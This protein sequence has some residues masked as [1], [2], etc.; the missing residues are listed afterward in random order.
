MV[1][2]YQ[3]ILGLCLAFWC[4]DAA[5]FYV[6]GVAPQDF[7]K[8]DSIEVRAI[9]MTSS[10]TQL[11]F[12]YYNLPFCKPQSGV[13]EYKSQNLG[14]ILRG[15]RISNTAYDLRMDTPVQCQAL[16]YDGKPT[17]WNVEDSTNLHYRISQEYFVHFIVDNLPSATQFLIPDTNEV[18]YEPGFR[19][20][21][22]RD[23]KMYL[24]N[25]LKFIMSY[26]VD[27]EAEESYRVV[28]FRVETAS[29]DASEYTFN[30]D[31]TCLIKDNPKLQEVK[32]KQGNR[33]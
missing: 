7:K 31:G 23:D 20:G 15:D 19:L 25:H 24:N 10:H 21:V 16:C 11:P 2:T 26:H 9:K 1:K 8:G 22:N 14:E 33:Y 28:G 13:V 30:S 29:I 4:R 17:E 32:D 12:E 6:P 3:V 5:G 18:Q 27:P